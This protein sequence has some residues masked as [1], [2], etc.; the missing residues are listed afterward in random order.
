MVDRE[1]VEKEIDWLVRIIRSD[2]DSLKLKTLP[3]L[4]RTLIE[5]QIKTRSLRLK[6]L[7]EQ[8]ADLSSATLSGKP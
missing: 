3:P 5:T 4:S 8:V 7:R 1:A 2:E 6:G